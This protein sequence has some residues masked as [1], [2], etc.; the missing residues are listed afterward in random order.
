VATARKINSHTQKIRRGVLNWLDLGV[1][2]IPIRRGKSPGYAEWQDLRL[3]K[4]DY[5]QHFTNGEAIG[6]LWGEP[7]GGIIDLDLDWDEA[8]FIAPYLLPETLMYGRGKRPSTHYLYKCS[9][10]KEPFKWTFLKK[11]KPVVEL[12]S[13]GQQSVLPPSR[14]PDND[15]YRIEHDVPITTISKPELYEVIQ[16]VV[17]GAIFLRLYPE[18][19]LRH[20]YVHGITGT[21]LHAKWDEARVRSVIEAV[22]QEAPEKSKD[23]RERKRTMQNTIEKF[24][25]GS[26]TIWGLPKLK[27]MEYLAKDEVERIK[28]LL[29]ID[30]TPE[31]DTYGADGEPVPG[32]KGWENPIS[33]LPDHLR[34]APGL[35]GEIARW[36]H[37]DARYQVPVFHLMVGLMATALATRNRYIVSGHRTP[38]QPYFMA[39]A[40]TGTGKDVIRSHL[41]KLICKKMQRY[42]MLPEAFLSS[43]AVRRELTNTI[44]GFCWLWDEAGNEMASANNVDQGVYTTLTSCFGQAQGSIGAVKA[45]NN[46]FEHVEKPFLTV[47]ASTQP[48]LLIRA[49]R[50]SRNIDGGFLGRFLL[51]DTGGRR[52]FRNPERTTT[53]PARVIRKLRELFE[54]P[55]GKD[56]KPTR[57]RLTQEA[58]DFIYEYEDSCKER[59]LAKQFWARAHQHALIIAGIVA[60]GINPEKPLIDMEVMRWA[61]DLV[62]W[63]INSWQSRLVEAGK[64][65]DMDYQ[66]RKLR[67]LEECIVYCLRPDHQIKNLSL[68]KAG[69]TSERCIKEGRIPKTVLMK[70]L[71][72]TSD[73]LIDLLESLI[74]TG[75][76][77]EGVVGTGRNATVCY[78]VPED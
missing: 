48:E 43:Q 66:E 51:F 75:S 14:H 31:H 18:A 9:A 27:E 69:S 22:I 1:S 33:E 24:R 46:S 41:Q 57:I 20:D 15:S 36:S 62:T 54:M 47:C 3:S 17:L 77:V 39:V 37:S 23:R 42:D 58:D 56:D 50:Q 74:E 55:G 28:N 68:V 29:K 19:G 73:K 52:V 38:L 64:I 59:V 61:T 8:A 45:I 76:V 44:D 26:S 49:M 72:L 7:S 2:P 10:A 5:K 60:V 78:W 34:S 13:T 6:G 21:L 53:L 11:D 71:A 32:P 35:V 63:S 70:R 25:D 40:E 67:R 65:K 4:K 30:R 12:R 16:S